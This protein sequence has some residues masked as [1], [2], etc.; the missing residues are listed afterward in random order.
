MLLFLQY[1]DNVALHGNLKTGIVSDFG[2]MHYAS[3][4]YTV[5][6]ISRTYNECEDYVQ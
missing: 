4:E 6:F 5:Q 2:S 3:A 1:D